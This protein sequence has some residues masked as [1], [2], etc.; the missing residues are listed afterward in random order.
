MTG[1]ALEAYRGDLKLIDVVALM[2][3]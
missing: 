1:R 2:A 3:G